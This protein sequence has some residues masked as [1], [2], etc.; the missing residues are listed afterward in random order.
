MEL[1]ESI[2]FFFQ[3]LKMKNFELQISSTNCIGE[4]KHTCSNSE[5]K[6]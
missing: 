1:H 3:K 4:N 5:M 6:S 2:I